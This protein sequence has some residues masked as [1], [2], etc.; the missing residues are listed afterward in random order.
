[1]AITTAMCTSFKSELLGGIHDLD[2]HTLKLALIKASPS[3]TYNATTTNYSTVTGNSDEASGTNYSAG[4]QNLDGAAISV[5]GTTAIVDFTD[6]VFASATISADGCIIYNSS[7]SNKAICVIDFG[8]TKT[9]TNGDF[10][11]Q[12]PTADASNAIIRIA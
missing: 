9:S 6:E 2:T 8:G 10:T 1:M 11:I 5:S 4:G 12:F 3:G 7:A